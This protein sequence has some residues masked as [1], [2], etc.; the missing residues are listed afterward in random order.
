[1]RDP[2]LS[3]LLAAA[4]SGPVPGT[5]GTDPADPADAAA[6]PAN[7]AARRGRAGKQ[8]PSGAVHASSRAR[9]RGAGPPHQPGAAHGLMGTAASRKAAVL[10]GR[11][12]ST[13]AAQV[14]R[15]TSCCSAVRGLVGRAVRNTARCGYRRADDGYPE[16]VSLP[17][18]RWVSETAA[19]PP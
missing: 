6:A 9:P 4:V 3:D 15:S 7:R 14:V 5:P 17:S 12:S 13:S 8:A 11:P 1:M 18:V 10:R 19:A 2:L 16:R